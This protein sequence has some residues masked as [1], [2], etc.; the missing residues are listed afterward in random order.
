MEPLYIRPVIALNDFLPVFLAGGLVIVFG[1]FYAVVVTLV[2]MQKLKK[3]YMFLAYLFW[4][5]QVYSIYFLGLKIHTQPFTMKAMMI[6]MVAYLMVPHIYYLII[7]KSE[8][9]YKN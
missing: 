2:K 4:G 6:A 8:E 7:S 3:I 9:R 5:L 1:A